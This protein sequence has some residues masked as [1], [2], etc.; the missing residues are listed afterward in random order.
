MSITTKMIDSQQFYIKYIY[1]SMARMLQFVFSLIIIDFVRNKQSLQLLC[2]SHDDTINR[3]SY[4]PIPISSHY[5]VLYSSVFDLGNLQI[6]MMQAFTLSKI[7]LY[8]CFIL[9]SIFKLDVFYLLSHPI[10]VHYPTLLFFGI[11]VG[12][13]S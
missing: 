13:L 2:S 11:L 12:F 5:S 6:S 7:Q 10:L 4:F 1:R 8:S 9:S 3:I